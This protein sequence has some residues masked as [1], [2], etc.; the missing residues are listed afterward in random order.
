[1]G[2]SETHPAR[3]AARP[4]QALR[5]V[6]HSVET[7]LV[8]AGAVCLLAYAGACACASLTQR[9]ESAA[10]DETLRLRTQE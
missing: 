2:D 9:R 7:A 10:F 1:M 4:S 3:C 6:L 8:L 5:K